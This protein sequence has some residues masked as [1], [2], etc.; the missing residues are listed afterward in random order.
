[1]MA[2]LTTK[3]PRPSTT[4]AK[5]SRPKNSNS[6][7]GRYLASKKRA[8]PKIKAT[9]AGG[10]LSF[11]ALKYYFS[12]QIIVGTYEIGLCHPQSKQI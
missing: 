8:D 4:K 6:P 9:N 3:K 10:I 11:M 5:I 1:M 7:T 12:N 2:I